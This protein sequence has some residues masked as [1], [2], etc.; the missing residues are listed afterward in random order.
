LD[1][2]PEV[3][4]ILQE[5]AQQVRSHGGP[6]G[7][8][9]LADHRLHG[10]GVAFATKYLSFCAD[11][12]GRE[13]TLILD[14][15]VRSWLGR[16][17]G[18]FPRLDWRT[19]DYGKYVSTVANWAVQLG[20]GAADIEYLMFAGE[21]ES[22][23]ASQWRQAFAADRTPEAVAGLPSVTP[24]PEETAVLDAL[25][26][27]AETFADLPEVPTAE[28][29]DFERGLRQLRRIVLSRGRLRY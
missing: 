7:F 19:A 18:W 6:A 25:N 12:D 4:V 9:W 20:T 27:A 17:T 5:A 22:D 13:P 29:E 15:L 14:R 2:N 26:E 21:V 28:G 23:P 3:A 16:N 1:G 24:T 10:L 11:P 8:E